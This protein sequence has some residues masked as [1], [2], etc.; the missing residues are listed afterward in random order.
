MNM[1]PFSRSAKR[2]VVY[3]TKQMSR[4]HFAKSSMRLFAYD[5]LFPQIVEG[6]DKLL[7][8]CQ[9]LCNENKVY[10]NN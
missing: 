3:D 4:S 2:A 9:K 6:I 5:N 1:M 10:I 8:S 7:Q